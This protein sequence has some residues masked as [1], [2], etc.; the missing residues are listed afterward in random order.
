VN[1]AFSTAAR[2]MPDYLADR[3]QCVMAASS[4]WLFSIDT[5]FVHFCAL[6]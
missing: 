5:I 1:K 4:A 3:N 6:F 2:K